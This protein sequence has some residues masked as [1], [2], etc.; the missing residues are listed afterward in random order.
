M[1]KL[2]IAF[3]LLFSA[4]AATAQQQPTNLS[5]TPDRPT[6]GF[7][8]END[9]LP[10]RNHGTG[11]RAGAN[12]SLLQT[13]VR[14]RK[15]PGAFEMGFFHQRALSRAVSVQG[16]ALYYRENTTLGTSAGLRLPALFVVN[17]FYNVSLHAGPQLQVRTSGEAPRSISSALGA[18][19]TVPLA[20]TGLAPRLTT[21]LLVGGEAR[22]GFLRV[23]LRY[24]VPLRD[25]TDLK[26]TGQR[27]GSAWQAGQVQAY[28][29]AGF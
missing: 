22:V 4:G 25:L 7:T 15:L 11:L 17:P 14:D 20:S 21:A 19:G 6:R 28:L 10:A 18:E 16:E 2:L 5:N 12:W 23:G 29:G 1:K 27:V 26:A 8:D 24:G 9:E 3:C 13:A